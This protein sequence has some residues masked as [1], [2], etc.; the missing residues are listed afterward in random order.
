M[1]NSSFNKLLIEKFP[2]L[3]SNFTGAFNLET[4]KH[5]SI[6]MIF[7]PFFLKAIN[8]NDIFL[9]NRCCNF[10]DE[11]YESD[12]EITNVV[13]V[14]II[15]GLADNSIDITKFPFKEV[16]LAKYIEYYNNLWK[17]K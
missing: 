1:T 14:S 5:V 10:V 4:G 9:I 15:E 2:E 7:M 11:M 16:N 17:T 13:E 12:D 6:E 3:N 8:T